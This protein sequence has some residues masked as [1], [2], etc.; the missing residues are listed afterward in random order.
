ML[1]PPIG[2]ETGESGGGSGGG[3]SAQVSFSQLS[4]NIRT[5]F[6]GIEIDPSNAN[7]GAV[8]Q[9]LPALLIGSY[10]NTLT[11]VTANV[12]VQ[13]FS[14]SQAGALFGNGSLLHEMAI[15]WF[16]NNPSTPVW[17]APVSD[18]GGAS[19]ST[20]TL[21]FTIPSGSIQNGTLALYINGVYYGVGITAGMTVSQ[22]ATAVAAALSNQYGCPV[23][24]SAA[25][26]V[27]TL[28]SKGKGTWTGGIDVRINYAATDATPGNLACAIASATTGATNPSLSTLIT[29]IANMQFGFYV[30]P[31]TDSTSLGAMVTELT[32]RWG[33]MVQTEGFAI[34]AIQGSQGTVA[35]VGAALN[36]QCLHD[37]G[38]QQ[39]AERVLRVG[40]GPRRSGRDVGGHR[41]GAGRSTRFP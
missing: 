32:R 4:S 10:D 28:T 39:L 2:G 5:P 1:M 19:T 34:A 36:S 33:A 24:A 8:Q 37:H 13:I 29:N 40:G 14:P 27:V 9:N 21:T 26:G 35:A 41:S 20:W 17:A 16:A 11:S 30:L 12:P 18:A 23:T 3:P 6:I 31:Y 7:G 15:A 22:V 38:L 25:L